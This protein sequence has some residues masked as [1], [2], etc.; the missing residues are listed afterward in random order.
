MGADAVLGLRLM[1]SSVM[2]A[3]SGTMACGT[4]VIPVSGR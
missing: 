4:A 2:Q 1:T 3:A